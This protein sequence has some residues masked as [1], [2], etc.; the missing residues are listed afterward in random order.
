VKLSSRSKKSVLTRARERAESQLASE[1]AGTAGI[2]AVRRQLP[3]AKKATASFIARQAEIATG[4]AAKPTVVKN[5]VA[6]AKAPVITKVGKGAAAAAG[7][8]LGTSAALAIA[9]GAGSYFATKWVLEKLE[10]IK[11]RKVTA[12]DVKFQAALAYRKARQDAALQLGRELTTEEHKV[13]A[14]AFKAK[15]KTLGGI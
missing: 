7:V 1:I 2:R 10:A 8:S 6:L 15:L 4:A 9:A 14:D 13:L 11:D 12:A 5:I 3:K